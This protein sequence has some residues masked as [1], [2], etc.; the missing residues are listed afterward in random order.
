MAANPFDFSDVSDLPEELRKGLTARGG[1]SSSAKDIMDILQKAKEAGMDK[2]TVSML[3][4]A[5]YRMKI[6]LPSKQT[7]VKYLNEA[8]EKGVVTKPTRQTYALT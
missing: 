4:A 1:S 7:V 8:V 5:A 2:V 6:K 3:I